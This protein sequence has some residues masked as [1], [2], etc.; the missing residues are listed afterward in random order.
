MNFSTLENHGN[1]AEQFSIGWYITYIFL[2][3]IQPMQGLRSSQ[4][5]ELLL[6]WL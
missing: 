4:Y 3:K 6:K 2:T 5:R 1:E